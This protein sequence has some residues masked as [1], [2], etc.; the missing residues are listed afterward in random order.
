M[1]FWFTL[2]L[3]KLMH[4]IR[5]HIQSFQQDKHKQ[6]KTF[7]EV[8]SNFCFSCLL[9]LCNKIY[10]PCCDAC[11][12]QTKWQGRKEGV[13]VAVRVYVVQVQTGAL[14]HRSCCER[15]PQRRQEEKMSGH[16]RMHYNHWCFCS[17]GILLF[18]LSVDIRQTHRT[19][20]L[21]NA[22]FWQD[23]GRKCISNRSKSSEHQHQSNKK[24]VI[25][26]SNLVK[27]ELYTMKRED[28][29]LQNKN[30]TAFSPFAFY[31]FQ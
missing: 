22:F 4:C 27:Y 19:I 2:Q 14:N 8:R 29:W 24:R 7:L 26:L 9:Q 12:T 13:G 17:G 23:S 20:K 18:H 30:R 16:P 3:V 25:R 15:T 11:A 31:F 6:N 5:L 1:Q 28:S 10:R 21:I